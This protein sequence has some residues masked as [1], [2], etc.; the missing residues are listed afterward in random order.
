MLLQRS[1]LN[2]IIPDE[3]VSMN[4]QNQFGAEGTKF[5]THFRKRL[6]GKNMLSFKMKR[7]TIE[8]THD[9]YEKY[10]L[11]IRLPINIGNK[12]VLENPP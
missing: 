4:L 2:W 12:P 9:Q 10:S 6:L 3:Y 1:G 5:K 8:S 11:P 7:M